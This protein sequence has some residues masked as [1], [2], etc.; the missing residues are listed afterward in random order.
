MRS[1]ARSR[2]SWLGQAFY[3]WLRRQHC[4]TFSPA[5][6]SGLPQQLRLSAQLPPSPSGATQITA[7]RRQPGEPEPAAAIFLAPGR[8]PGEP[9]ARSAPLFLTSP[10][11]RAYSQQ[12]RVSAKPQRGDIGLARHVSARF[13][14]PHT[15][16]PTTP[17]Y[18]SARQ[19]AITNN[20]AKT[21]PSPTASPTRESRLLPPGGRTPWQ[22]RFSSA[23]CPASP[24]AT[25]MG[26]GGVRA[27]LSCGLSA[28]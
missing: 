20:A 10:L 17:H 13:A 27:I 26:S 15:A 4:L 5:R 21:R 3:A 6:F 2:A 11:Q 12:L 28:P 23:C 16:H 14:P 1:Q 18:P 9:S 25:V 8:K 24:G 22:M 19:G 7:P